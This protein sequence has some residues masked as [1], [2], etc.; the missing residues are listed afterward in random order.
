MIVESTV[1]EDSRQVDGRR[2]VREVHVDDVG[3]EHHVTYLAESKADVNAMLPIR[4]AQIDE[5][6][7]QRQADEQSS[8]IAEKERAVELLKLGDDSI[9]KILMVP[10]ERVSDEKTKLDD[11]SKAALEA[12]SVK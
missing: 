8:A 6:I 4:A 1:I 2:H 3:V 11:A 9:A 10:I 12:E 7:S 5:Q